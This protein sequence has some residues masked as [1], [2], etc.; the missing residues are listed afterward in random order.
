MGCGG[1]VLPGA[2]ARHLRYQAGQQA[3]PAWPTYGLHNV[4][5]ATDEP[6]PRWPVPRQFP[7]TFYDLRCTCGG[8]FMY[9]AERYR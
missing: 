4:T 6:A 2:V 7:L 3:A 8:P 5:T 9:L 1:T